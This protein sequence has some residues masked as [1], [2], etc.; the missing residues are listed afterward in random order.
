[1]QRDAI[2]I[3]PDYERR[4]KVVDPDDSHLFKSLG[5]AAEN[6]VH[7]AAADG[8]A[9]RVRFDAAQDA[10]VLAFE[11][12]AAAR[13]G[14][15]SA[16][17]F[18]RRCTRTPYDGQAVSAAE[19]AA[20]AAAATLDGVTPMFLQSRP[21]ME[22]MLEYVRQGNMAQFDD[23]AFVKELRD[24]VRFNEADAVASGDGLAGIVGGR[25]S[26]PAWLGRPLFG[27]VASGKQ[28]SEADAKAIRSSA[29]IVAF[30]A[31]HNDKA[32]WVAA[33]RAYERFALQ[34]TALEIRNAFI[35]QPIEVRHLRPQLLGWL[36]VPQK[37]VHLIVRFGHGQSSLHSLRRPVDAV[38]IE[39]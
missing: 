5:C 2:V 26:L 37:H 25:P 33:G 27:F 30:V 20:L 10:V 24:W 8:F 11:P 3:A 29:G 38:L 18:E 4:C 1:L 7:A 17:I 22:T 36:G 34:A 16:A 6:L 14:N 9:A 23:P 28:Q 35:N 15:L 12:S 19:Q 21:Q 32:S 31:E 13:Q 39:S